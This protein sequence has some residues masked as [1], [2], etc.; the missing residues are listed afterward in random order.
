MTAD[1]REEGAGTSSVA[2]RSAAQPA[3]LAS[4]ALAVPRQAWWRRLADSQ[5]A[6]HLLVLACYLVAGVAVTWPRA[7]W[8]VEVG[9]RYRIPLLVA[10]PGS[11]PSFSGNTHCQVIEITMPDNSTFVIASCQ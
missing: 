5:A 3:V 9:H 10:H 4:T 2:V 7:T 6:R 1:G 11:L 8:L